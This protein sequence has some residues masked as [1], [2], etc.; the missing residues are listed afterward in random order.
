MTWKTLLLITLV[1]LLA[2]CQPAA[3]TPTSEPPATEEPA[4]ATEKLSEPYP[5][6]EATTASGDQEGYPAP[7]G[8]TVE[9]LSG[10]PGYPAPEEGEMIS[11]EEAQSLILEGQVTQVTQLHNLSV[12]LTLEDGSTVQTIEPNIDDVF[13]VIEQCGDPCANI[14]IATE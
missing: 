6:Q 11:W 2:A 10:E 12:Y 5:A 9:G 1:F 8:Q 3:P 13:D 14:A 4:I 7:Q